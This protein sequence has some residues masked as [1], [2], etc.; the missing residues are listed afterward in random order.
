MEHKNIFLKFLL[1]IIAISTFTLCSIVIYQ[2]FIDN[3]QKETEII[4][5]KQ[6]ISDYQKEIADNTIK[7]ETLEKQ[8]TTIIE[9]NDAIE[10]SLP[11]STSVYHEWLNANSALEPYDLYDDLSLA[12]EQLVELNEEGFDGTVLYDACVKL[13]V[14]AS[15]RNNIDKYLSKLNKYYDYSDYYYPTKQFIDDLVSAE[16]LTKNGDSYT[17][18]YSTL[19]TENVVAKL[20][21][22]KDSANALMGLLRAIGWD[23]RSTD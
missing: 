20:S 16:L 11:S 13:L 23:V 2:M 3:H 21:L 5:L 17:W 7:F 8:L 1:T 19:T 6:Q 22:T 10:A 14:P 9:E 18:N 15:Y 4:L 12:Y